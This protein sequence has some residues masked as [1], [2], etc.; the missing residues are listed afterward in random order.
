MAGIQVP[1][2]CLIDRLLAVAAMHERNGLLCTPEPGTLSR[3]S[4][5]VAL[6][7]AR[8]HEQAAEDIRKAVALLTSGAV[9]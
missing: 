2:G 4:G 7:H 3:A 9:P 1:T 8:I 5:E 6:R